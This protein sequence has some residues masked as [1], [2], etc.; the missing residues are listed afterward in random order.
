M[1]D[2]T[3]AKAINYA[4]KFILN[5]ESPAAIINYFPDMQVIIRS[6]LDEAFR[7]KL[8]AY[9]ALLLIYCTDI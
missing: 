4:A 5:K 3:E 8:L 1:P 6:L 9:V 7:P 2:Q